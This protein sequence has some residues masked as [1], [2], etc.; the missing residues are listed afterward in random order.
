MSKK[1]IIES[2]DDWLNFFEINSLL[3][4][5]HG[6]F[7]EG[8]LKLLKEIYDC[9]STSKTIVHFFS[10]PP[11]SGKT[12]II[13][14]LAKYFANK[15]EN[16]CVVLSNNFLKQDFIDS[17][18]NIYN[19]IKKL[20]ILTIYDYVNSKKEYNYVLIDE[21]HNIKN[22]L[23]FNYQLVKNYEIDSSFE[24]FN[25]LYY[26]Y[27]PSNNDFVAKQLDYP[28]SKEII[29]IIS[30]SNRNE[31]KEVAHDPTTWLTFI[32][33]WKNSN[34]IL[35]K[36]V[37]TEILSSFKL[38]KENLLLF[39]ATPLSNSELEIYCGI[40]S[41]CITRSNDIII[42]E[43]NIRKLYISILDVFTAEDKINFLKSILNN[44]EAKTLILF[45]NH[46]SCLKAY[47]ELSKEIKNTYIYL[48]FSEKKNKIYDD[49]LKNNPA[50]LFTSSTVFWEGI[51]IP[52]L[53]VLIIFE[54]P[55]P[56]P[57]VFDLMGKK[58]ISGRE[59]MIRRLE[60]GLGRI[61]RRQ[62]EYGLGITFFDLLDI[63]LDLPEIVC[64][65]KFSRQKSWECLLLLY[66]MYK[67]KQTTVK[68][69]IETGRRSL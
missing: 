69:V 22:Y 2:Y 35:L 61:G 47:T 46:R 1:L 11:S 20:D 25:I 58:P 52:N 42:A 41:E 24:L 37:N 10:A 62:N 67:L 7:L 5:K 8:Q 21:A 68:D 9:L 51:S 14:L 48:P 27:L 39:S 54:K 31:I 57:S 34:Y 16:V 4:K 28:S 45:N 55:V 32:Y 38:P 29:D 19:G 43:K 18:K 60:Q 3:F 15:S 59:D 13:G 6:T 44:I 17:L 12:H 49:F 50:H 30:S 26:R 63:G 40:K 66:N 33:I 56:R 64:S 36:F 65:N 23:D 53:D